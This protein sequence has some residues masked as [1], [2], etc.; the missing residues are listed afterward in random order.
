MLGTALFFCFARLRA[1]SISPIICWWNRSSQ[2]TKPGSTTCPP[3]EVDRKTIEGFGE[4]LLR[5]NH[6]Q[7]MRQGTLQS[8][9]CSMELVSEL[10]LR[11]F[12]RDHGNG[13][14]NNMRP[15]TSCL[16]WSHPRSSSVVSPAACCVSMPS[17]TVAS[18]ISCVVCLHL[19]P[20][21]WNPCLFPRLE[22][23]GGLWSRPLASG[24][25]EPFFARQ[26]TPFPCQWICSAMP[27]PS[28]IAPSISLWTS[29]NFASTM[30]STASLMRFLPQQWIPLRLYPGFFASLSLLVLVA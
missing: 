30:D 11:F 17:G 2:K 14:C 21:P 3:C 16:A 22:V 1:R 25:V 10:K 26:H 19:V 4:E 29:L 28:S 8:R 27:V 5:K 12:A 6:F 9:T 18:S 13:S 15:P 23:V 20:V 24:R 7:R